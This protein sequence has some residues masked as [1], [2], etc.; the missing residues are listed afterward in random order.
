MENNTLSVRRSPFAA[1]RWLIKPVALV[2]SGITMLT[3][4]ILTHAT[5]WVF[6]V[7]LGLLMLPLSILVL[8]LN[9]NDWK[10][11][12][13]QIDKYG[14]LQIIY[15]TWLKYR[16]IRRGPIAALV[17][18]WVVQRGITRILFNFGD[19]YLTV[20]WSRRPFILRDVQAPYSVA[21]QIKRLASIYSNTSNDTVD[22]MATILK[23]YDNEE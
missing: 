1:L 22:V 5:F 20:G 4:L 8:Y 18:A 19:I 23:K 12:I 10:D 15:R 21:A 14:T 3:G 2:L 7:V 13:Y 9:F 17:D 6:I 11:D 16:S